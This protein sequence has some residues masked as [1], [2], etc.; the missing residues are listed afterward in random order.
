MLLTTT[1]AL[2][3]WNVAVKALSEGETIVLLRKGGIKE[4]N[5]RFQ[6]L[7]QRFWLY[8]TYEH[9]KPELLKPEYAS[10]VK[11]VPSQ[12]HPETVEITCAAEITDVFSVSNANTV[13][14]LF[15]YH[16]WNDRFVSDRLAWKPRQPISV[17]LLR[18]YRL[19]RS[20]LIPYRQ[21]YGGCKSWI[22]LLKTINEPN[23]TPVLNQNEYDILADTIKQLITTCEN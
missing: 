12:W 7:H 4:V 23:L 18:A 16:I 17:L 9:Q 21:E 2:K 8:P 1:Q 20:L 13:R 5:N 19:D 11:T 14:A 22:D 10:E 3:E 6:I 15:P